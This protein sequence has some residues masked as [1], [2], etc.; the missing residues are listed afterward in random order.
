MFAHQD[1]YDIY[2]KTFDPTA[3][4]TAYG[5]RPKF[6][7]AVHSAMTGGQ[8]YGPTQYVN[9]IIF[10]PSLFHLLFGVYLGEIK[11]AF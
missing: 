5:Q 4:A 2:F 1:F 6:V 9:L 8:N 3:S 7:R 10:R 11:E